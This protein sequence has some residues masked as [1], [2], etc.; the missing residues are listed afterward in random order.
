MWEPLQ[1]RIGTWLRNRTWSPLKQLPWK[2]LGIGPA[3]PTR[4][5]LEKDALT[6]LSSLHMAALLILFVCLALGILCR[7]FASSFPEA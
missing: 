4:R 7:R 2:A 1:R 6:L 5:Q 3:V